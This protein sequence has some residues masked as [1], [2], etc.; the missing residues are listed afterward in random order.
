MGLPALK[1]QLMDVATPRQPGMSRTDEIISGQM[2]TYTNDSEE[3]KK[4][5]ESNRSNVLKLQKAMDRVRDRDT[6]DFRKETIADIRAY[7]NSL[8]RQAKDILQIIRLCNELIR[9]EFREILFDIRNPLVAFERFF[10]SLKDGLVHVNL[11]K[12]TMNRLKTIVPNIQKNYLDLINDTIH[13][14]RNEL[15]Y[16]NSLGLNFG[17]MDETK[18]TEYALATHVK[19]RARIK[20]RMNGKAQWIMSQIKMLTENLQRRPGSQEIVKSMQYFSQQFKALVDFCEDRVEV[21]DHMIIESI[22]LQRDYY[23]DLETLKEELHSFYHEFLMDQQHLMESTDS[24]WKTEQI[25]K[26]I[27]Q[28]R[29]Y[30]QELT[31]ELNQFHKEFTSSVK[32]IEKED[33]KLIKLEKKEEKKVV[34]RLAKYK[35]YFIRFTATL[36]AGSMITGATVSALP[37]EYKEAVAAKTYAAVSE[38]T[39][40]VNILLSVDRDFAQRYGRHDVR[41]RITDSA[42][43]HLEEGRYIGSHVDEK[44][45]KFV[46]GV[47]ER[48]PSITKDL[49]PMSC[50]KYVNTVLSESVPGYQKRKY[51]DQTIADFKK[52]GW[53][54]YLVTKDP[55]DKSTFLKGQTAD[56]FIRAGKRGSY[57]HVGRIDNFVI[58]PGQVEKFQKSLKGRVALVSFNSGFHSAFILDGNVVQAHYQALGV[59]VVEGVFSLEKHLSQNEVGIWEF[60]VVAVAPN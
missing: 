7:E 35:K 41:F 42:I 51:M 14:V 15:K 4:V 47:L 10:M 3:I 12:D 16:Y 58:G 9:N 17:L 32:S 39:R 29:T 49:T 2:A 13:Y 26:R 5:R 24:K 22:V 25:K 46:S 19:E 8:K 34:S 20:Q 6:S 56:D 52:K 1:R 40:Y 57:P 31:E 54:V 21:A 43:R 44:L 36:L 27:S 33:L 38:A 59:P 50:M 28:F 55:T 11:D 53:K 37:H 60:A 23:E 18:E 48:Y 30:Q 45:P